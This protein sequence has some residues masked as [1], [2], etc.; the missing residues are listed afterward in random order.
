MSEYLSVCPKC[1]QQILGDTAYVGM[2]VACPVCL[3]EIALPAPPVESH[4][5][6]PAPASLASSQP[7]A[8]PQRVV[9]NG[10]KR[11]LLMMTLV[12]VA[13]LLVLTAGVLMFLEQRPDSKATLPEAAPPIATVPPVATV[14]PVSQP[15][16]ASNTPVAIWTFDQD[17]GRVARD[18]TG[19]GF[20]ARLVGSGAAWSGAAKVGTGA[21]RLG[22]S[23]YAEVP[24]AV[25]D[26][27]KSFTVAAWVNLLV[28]DN[29]Q[30]CQTVVS[31]D[32][33]NVSG[34]YLQFSHLAGHRFVFNRLESDVAKGTTKTI[35]AGTDF[36]PIP[37][38]WYHLAGVYDAEA[39]TLALYVDGVLQHSVPY[40]SA[41]QAPG[42]T[43][44][45]RGLWQKANVDFVNG[46]IDDVR[47][48]GAALTAEQIRALAAQ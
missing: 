42:K 3:Q 21:L 1:R 36:T 33:N 9:N 27:T 30:P 46:S 18:A 28:L 15:V 16:A 37:N 44:I 34:F 31:I 32:G 25:V 22:H 24:S 7:V 45:G 17:D 35:M 10:G 12:V 5:P 41:W 6:A 43:A 39:K 14:Q 29:N 23:S 19:N 40:T 26:T 20:D 13:L 8:S 38:K 47:I 11:S 48:Y 4:A 2:R